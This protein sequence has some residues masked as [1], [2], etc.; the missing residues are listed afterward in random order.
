MTFG[1]VFIDGTWH[2]A[3]FNTTK[4][5]FPRAARYWSSEF[6]KIC[7][8]GGARKRVNQVTFSMSSMVISGS[9]AGSVSGGTGLPL[10]VSS[11][12]DSGVVTPISWGNAPALNSIKVATAALRPNRPTRPSNV[13]LDRTTI[14]CAVQQWSVWAVSGV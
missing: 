2:A 3:H 4:S 11:T 8:G 14:P 12:G 9:G 10:M 6:E 1:P 5:F 7:R 13:V